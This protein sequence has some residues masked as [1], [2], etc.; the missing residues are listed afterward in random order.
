[1][2]SV[3]VLQEKQKKEKPSLL[4]MLWSPGEQFDRIKGNPKV[5][6]PLL[7]IGVMYGIGMFLMT[8]MLDMEA[9]LGED[10]SADQAE[11]IATI[12]K[13]TV[14]V[15][16]V[17]SPLLIVLVSSS[18]QLLIAKIVSSTVSFKKL[19]SMNTYIAFIG[20]LGL[21]LNMIVSA[22]FGG[23]PE[24]YVTSLAGVLNVEK[25]G[26][27]S[28]IEVFSIWQM[29]L[30]AIG[31]H[32]VAQVSKKLSWTIAIVF[33]LFSVVMSLFNPGVAG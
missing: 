4:G 10:I 14:V 30:T 22:A 26:L 5:W 31:L 16:G 18:V 1:V 20:A 21:L 17:L 6:L 29:F 28:S 19:Y 2:E 13:I 3:A 8:S 24:I 7:I 11:S 33:F 32:K 9:L 12:S 23:N 27:S 15:T 25:A